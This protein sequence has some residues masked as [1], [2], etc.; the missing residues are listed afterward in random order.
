MAARYG[1][2]VV[3]E[4][5]EGGEFGR[6]HPSVAARAQKQ[7]FAG[8]NVVRY[9]S[10][11]IG[12]R[13]GLKAISVTSPPTGTIQGLGNAI[14]SGTGPW[15]WVCISGSFYRVDLGAGTVSAAY[16]G[17][18]PATIT[19]PM[20]DAYAGT[21]SYV[22][23]A[24]DTVY[25]L[26]HSAGSVTAITSDAD[27]SVI[28]WYDVNNT[29]RL[30]ANKGSRVYFS[31]LYP[32][33]TTWDPASY[34]DV[35]TALEITHMAPFRDGILISKASGEQFIFTGVP[36]ATIGSAG[37]LRR[38]S[39]AGGPRSWPAALTVEG[40]MAWYVGQRRDFPSSYNGALHA[41]LDWLAF[42]GGVA[43]DDSGVTPGFRFVPVTY[44]SPEAW[45]LLSGQ[46]GSGAANRMLEF[47]GGIFT[48]HTFGVNIDPWSVCLADNAAEAVGQSTRSMLLTKGSTGSFYHYSP[49]LDRP[50]FTSDALAQ[51]GDASTT[52]LDADLGGLV[53]WE[54]EGNEVRAAEVIVLYRGWNTG[55]GSNNRIKVQVHALNRADLTNATVGAGSDSE[56]TVVD[57]AG[58]AFT[59]S[60]VDA[61]AVATGSTQWG[62]GFRVD[63]NGLRGVAIDRVLVRLDTRRRPGG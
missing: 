43:A 24:G 60:G 25:L 17:T 33:W 35:G 14:G 10:G 3:F 19:K 40:N 44:L 41:D 27:G 42:T 61:R 62:H 54:P 48:F 11:L 55:S 20:Q 26:N 45:L 2:T 63:V 39:R 38:L 58:S 37:T 32:G 51:P 31:D 30:F 36:G 5:W 23:C 29:F 52:P 49:G 13:P 22:T 18:G 47:T 16:T 4:G 56:Q 15:V 9:R 53:W 59:T 1:D 12:P 6:M 8:S 28:A 57:L 34:F 50:G 7:M 21:T 46:S